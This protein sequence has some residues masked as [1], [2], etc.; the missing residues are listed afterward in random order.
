M[1]PKFEA[2]KTKKIPKTLVKAKAKAKMDV[3]VNLI[4]N[5]KETLEKLSVKEIEAFILKADDAYYN[6]GETLVTDDIYDLVKEHLGRIAPNSNVNKTIGAP[7][8]TSDN[9]KAKLPY[10]MGSMDKI[11]NDNST[12][13][14]FRLKFANPP[15]F[16]LSDKLDGNSAMYYCNDGK[17]SLF[18]RGNGVEGQDISHLIGHVQGIPMKP[19]SGESMIAIRGEMIISKSDFDKV[20][21]QGANARNMVAG[22]M[23]AK[24]PNVELLKYVQF[25]AY[26]IPSHQD[27]MTPQEQFD[28]MTTRGFRV[29]PYKTIDSRGFNFDNLSEYLVTRR[30]TSPFEIDGIIVAHNGVHKLEVNKNP[31]SAFAFKSIITAETAEVVVQNV[32]WSI[33]KDGYYKPVV[34]IEAVKLAG[35][36][37]KRTTGFNGEFIETN[38]IGPGSRI[39]M[40]RSGDVIPYILQVLT[41]S[42]S[43]E[44]QMPDTP[45]EWTSSGKEIMVIGSNEEVDY[46]QVENFFTKIKVFGL[47]SAT[48][49]KLYDSGMNTP[50]SILFAKEKDLAGILGEKTTIKLM[51]N[52]AKTRASI[53]CVKLMDASNMFGRGFG[54]KR[55][56]SI[57]EAFPRIQDDDKY[58]PSKSELCQV[59]GVSSIT[60]DK[61]IVGLQKYRLFMKSSHIECEAPSAKVQQ[62]SNNTNIKKTLAD[63]VVLFTGFRDKE[64]GEEVVRRGGKTIDSFSK[65]VTVLVTKTEDSTSGKVQQAKALGTVEI[66]TVDAFRKKYIV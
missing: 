26:A 62:P 37:I 47:S 24:K 50:A 57:L 59:P 51:E 54:E 15:S 39:V 58:T 65:K 27:R 23:N 18:T 3:A 63:Q 64:L 20:S 48:I 29:V 1:A 61:F 21:D 41:P 49:R 13:D 55:L 42:A 45:Y 60:A 36:V 38:K 4:K 52:L 28:W 5:P 66:T 11:K 31:T 16:V 32:K 7:V 14:N 6:K 10:Y 12:L 35:V 22:L 30:K 17:V 9:R 53:E 43:G 46:K 8:V 25:I 56:Q 2:H 19:P 44:A 40:T 34:E 33:S